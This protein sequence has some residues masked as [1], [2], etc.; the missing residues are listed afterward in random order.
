MSGSTTLYPLAFGGLLMFKQFML[1]LSTMLVWCVTARAQ[2]NPEHVPD[3]L[4]PALDESEKV[5][6]PDK[7][8]ELNRLIAGLRKNRNALMDYSMP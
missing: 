3:A 2:V 6:T 1:A 8:V 5:E 4:P 7:K